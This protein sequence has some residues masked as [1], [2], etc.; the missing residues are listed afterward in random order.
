MGGAFELGVTA[1]SGATTPYL[2]PVM[3][4][5]AIGRHFPG[6]IELIRGGELNHG[7]LFL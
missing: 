6:I 1:L 4:S 2:A 3:G 5:Q 7:N